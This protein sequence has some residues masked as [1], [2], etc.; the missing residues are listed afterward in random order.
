MTA[1]STILVVE[2][3]AFVRDIFQRSLER[4]GFEVLT[5]AHGEEALASFRKGGI[6]LV[7]TDILMPE[8]DG[9]RLTRALKRESPSLPVIAISVINDMADSRALAL[10]A[11]ATLAV[12]KPVTPRELVKLVRQ[13][14]SP[15]PLQ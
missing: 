9:F 1:T 10:E 13:F 5:A 7:V 12:C 2:D 4:A 15:Q 11:G 8:L 14:V 6:G 3:D